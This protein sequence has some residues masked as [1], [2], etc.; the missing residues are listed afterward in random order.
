MLSGLRSFGRQKVSGA[1]NTRLI[2][3]DLLMIDK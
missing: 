1:N 3:Y 2:S